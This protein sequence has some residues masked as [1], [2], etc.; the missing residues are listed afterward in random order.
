VGIRPQQALYRP[1]A[2]AEEI[3]KQLGRL[4]K[5]AEIE[6]ERLIA[7]VDAIDGDPDFEPSLGYAR[8]GMPVDAGDD[9][10]SLGG[11]LSFNLASPGRH[12]RACVG[13]PRQA[14]EVENG[15]QDLH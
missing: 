11:T 12:Q 8:P 3:F 14:G 10:P 6:V 4:K 13:H 9:E 15:R 2:D 1:A 5:K 7:L